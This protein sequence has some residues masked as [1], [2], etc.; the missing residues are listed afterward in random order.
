MKTP[1]ALQ[2]SRRNCHVALLL[3]ILIFKAITPTFTQVININQAFSSD[4]IFAP[5][6]G[7]AA[8]YSLKAYGNVNLYSDSSLVRIV[9]VDSYGNHRLVFESYP[10]ITDT[11]SFV[12]SAGCDETCYMDGIVPDNIRIDLISAFLTLDSLKLDTNYIPNASELQAQAKWNNDSVKIAIMNQRIQ[13]EHMYWRAGRTTMSEFSFQQKEHRFGTKFN[14]QGHDFYKGGIFQ[15][16]PHQTFQQSNSLYVDHF[17]WRYR[18]DA[19][20][21]TSKYYDGDENETGWLT[22]IKNQQDCYT[23]ADFASVAGVE[24]YANL[25]FNNSIGNPYN[26]GNP[27]TP[28]LHHI[29]ADLSELEVIR[30]QGSGN[31]HDCCNTTDNSSALTYIVNNGVNDDDCFDYALISHEPVDCDPPSPPCSAVCT[32]PDDNI[33]I[34]YKAP[35][36]YIGSNEDYLKKKLIE[37]GPVICK[38]DPMPALNMAHAMLL[39]GFS[40]SKAGDTV[41]KS[42]VM[43]DPPIILDTLCDFLNTTTWI[44]KNSW[45][46][47]NF[48]SNAQITILNFKNDDTWYPTGTIWRQLTT[49]VLCSD[50][51]GDGYYWWG[52]HRD[53]SG[54]Q[55]SPQLCNCPPGVI[56]EEEDCNDN[57]VTAGPYATSTNNPQNQPLY[58]CI[59]NGCTTLPVPLDINTSDTWSTGEGDRHINQNIIIH[60]GVTLTIECQVFFSPEA[61]IIIE[62][63]GKLLLNGTLANQAR[64]TSGC[65]EFWSG[66]EVH[67]DPK[68]AQTESNQ[69]KVAILHGIIENSLCGIKNAN[70]IIPIEGGNP[71]EPLDFY[72]SGGIIQADL[73]TFRNNKT[74]IIF[75]PYRDGDNPNISYFRGCNFIISDALLDET[76]PYYFIKLNGVNKVDIL[77]CTF[78]NLREENPP[79]TYNQRGNGIYLYNSAIYLNDTSIVTIYGTEYFELKF[80]NLQ[81]GIRGFHSGLDPAWIT[82]HN[83]NILNNQFGIYL[84]GY[85]ESNPVS[86]YDNVFDLESNYSAGNQYGLYLDHCSGYKIQRNLVNGNPQAPGYQYGMLVNNSGIRTNFIYNNNFNGLYSALQGQN[87]NR[88]Y[89]YPDNGNQGPVPDLETGLCFKCN[90]FQN[91]IN[92]ITVTDDV[93]EPVGHGITRNQGCDKGELSETATKEP[94][95]NVFSPLP[96]PN[97]SYDIDM[98]ESV[99]NITYFHHHFTQYHRVIPDLINYIHNPSKVTLQE[100]RSILAVFDPIAS[101]P[102]DEYPSDDLDSLKTLFNEAKGKIDSLTG[103]FS[104]LVDEGSTEEK[105]SMVLTSTPSQ[106]SEVY[107]D[108]ITTSPY[109]SDTVLL[110]SAEKE[111]VLSNAMITDI[112]VANPQSAKNDGILDALDQRIIPLSDS[113]WSEIMGGGDTIADRERLEAELSG[114]VKSK[115][116]I[117]Y[118]LVR[119][120]L[121]DTLHQ[122]SK[123]SL[124]VLLQTDLVFSTQISLANYYLDQKDFLSAD[125]LLQSLTENYNIKPGDDSTRQRLISLIP[126]LQQ[127]YIDTI[128]YLIPDS[129]QQLTLQALSSNKSDITGA[130]ARNILIANGLLDYQ[131]SILAT[132]TLKSSKRYHSIKYGKTSTQYQFKIFP[133]PCKDY[134]TIESLTDSQTSG[135]TVDIINLE[136][137]IVDIYR[138]LNQRYILVVPMKEYPSGIYFVRINKNGVPVEIHRVIHLD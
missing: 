99:S 74:G 70:P 4:T 10:L 18:H 2:S 5:F 19:H 13:E 1:P 87:T 120:Y 54:N 119:F 124:L 25:F 111:D 78:R 95:G 53:D 104:Q 17:D 108:L 118:E 130:Y 133:N 83:A 66:I 38:I 137:K 94:A 49:P 73:A 113:M 32:D 116:N 122:W 11:S 63:G 131:E 31:F 12:F 126:L 128:G 45:G 28:V 42:N 88:G 112:M 41:Y 86:V 40:V 43:G 109:L 132:S 117:F 115:E 15:I 26:I 22:E 101:C 135:I 36:G 46:G 114:W 123:D 39:T 107:L 62:P 98:D 68:L 16:L 96:H 8:V 77:G 71:Y 48:Y 59:P 65:G 85:Q 75:Y 127:L 30:C 33:R 92:D 129:S 80:E 34:Q 69:G 23:C 103:L 110:S 82:L 121:N 24:A 60:S 51:D 106:S 44:F 72:P 47:T 89:Y 3:N 138:F 27:N 20:V 105:N 76:S 93:T 29:D 61:K 6:T 21:A 90:N 50:E 52:I 79:V 67:G 56:A 97:H 37:F 7:S 55:I 125:S 81:Y 91:C 134:I 9:L 14:L 64:L 57:D 58:S 84:S 102:D 35:I 136:N 100:H